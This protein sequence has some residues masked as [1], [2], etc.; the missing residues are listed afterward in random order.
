MS[1][2][3]AEL[4]RNPTLATAMDVA[5]QSAPV[6]AAARIS[7]IPHVAHVQHG[8][9]R[10]YELYPSVLRLLATAPESDTAV[11]ASYEAVE[12]EKE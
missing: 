12:E 4:L 8:I 11:E 1:G 9:D 5:S 2:E 6:K 7:D 10:G 3:L